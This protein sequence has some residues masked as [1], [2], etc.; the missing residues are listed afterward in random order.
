MM[1]EAYTIF[2]TNIPPFSKYSEPKN[3]FTEYFF[4][5]A[6]MPMLHIYPLYSQENDEKTI[7]QLLYNNS[8]LLQI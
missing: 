1:Q 7:Y 6:L 5:D 8:P 3:S 4:L 2:F